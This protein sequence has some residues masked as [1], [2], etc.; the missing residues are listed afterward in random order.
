MVQNLFS[1]IEGKNGKQL[2]L[3]IEKSKS[4]S[5][6]DEELIAILNLLYEAFYNQIHKYLAPFDDEHC[7]RAKDDLAEQ[8][9]RSHIGFI[10]SHILPMINDKFKEIGKKTKSKSISSN[11]EKLS[12][13]YM[14]YEKLYYNYFSLVA[15]RS[16][17][18]YALF[19]EL[20][21]P[22][23][24]VEP[25][26][27]C[28]SGYWYYANKMVLDNDVQFIEKQCPTGY[29]KSISDL[30]LMSFI[31]GINIDN[32]ILKITGAKG[33]VVREF[34]SLV[35]FLCSKR[36]SKVFPYFEQFN[37]ERQKVFNSCSTSNGSFKINGSKKSKNLY[38]VS[39]E[40][41]VNGERARY[42]FLDD[43]TQA[44]DAS[45]LKAHEKDIYKFLNE[46]F[47]RNYDQTDF[48]II[49]GGT[50]YSEYDLLS[51]V[52][53]RYG[54]DR[55]IVSQIN[56]YTKVAKSSGIVENGTSVFVVVPKLDYETD[57]STYP[58]K[59]PTIQARQMR[60]DDERMFMAMEQQTPLPPDDTPFYWNNLTQY[61][62][63]PPKGEQGRTDSC[64]ASL[65]PARKGKNYVAMPIFSQIGDK[66]FLVD[67]LYE[68]KP[69]D[70]VYNLIVS[71]IVQHHI[72]HLAIEINTDTSLKTLL[73]TKLKEQG[74]TFC[75]ISEIYSIGEKEV[76]IYNYESTIKNNI[77]FPHKNMYARSSP[78][79]KAM[80]HIISFSYDRKNEYDDSI[81]SLA[82]YAQQF[83]TGKNR[84]S[85]IRMLNLHK[86]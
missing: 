53:N 74:I 24:V 72:T 70:E 66:H 40:V 30:I 65:D 15:F 23:K 60:N 31:L 13:Y 73:N 50:T 59:F 58:S 57:E 68:L 5:V 69:M 17:K 19:L 80:L 84:A 79:G 44:I 29:G 43:I 25:A 21:F 33:N 45:N 83:L 75:K 11:Y 20:D 47:K 51:F 28:F 61:E 37:G 64:W 48:H 54:A 22:K 85:K 8:E 67:F 81:D 86:I 27:N 78:M 10:N 41:D 35:N 18:H 3:D 14:E 76:R 16:L 6:K 26:L 52:K 1:V 77:V 7:G 63:L 38:I 39:K 2:I 34:D 12:K 46:W 56:K 49:V 42:L 62:I 82:L 71:K 32:D 36:H 4:S 9:I 55:S